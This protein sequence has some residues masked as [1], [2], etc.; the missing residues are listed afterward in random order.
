MTGV[1]TCALPILIALVKDAST[2]V[3]NQN[4]INID[5]L[6]EFGELPAEIATP[7]AMAVV[8]VLQNAIEHGR[9]TNENV[10]LRAEKS[11]G[12]IRIVI[13]DGGPGIEKG[14]DVFATDQLGLQ[15]VRTLIVDEL[16]GEISVTA[17]SPSGLKVEI[18]TPI[19]VRKN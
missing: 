14:F 9:P 11:G 16:G 10:E 15:I 12:Q 3:E 18:R 13:S 4:P 17:N 8:E 5:L 7:L 6:G 2:V 1:Q 19:V